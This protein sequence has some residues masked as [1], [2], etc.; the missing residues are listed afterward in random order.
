MENKPKPPIS[1]V[2]QNE[3]RTWISPTVELIGRNTIES[4]PTSYP[5]EGKHI[6]GGSSSITVYGDGIGS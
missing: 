3:K 2:A 1:V 4:G 6:G 5:L